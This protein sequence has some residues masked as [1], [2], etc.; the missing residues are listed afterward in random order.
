METSALDLV[1]VG[2]VG[3]V[4]GGLLTFTGGA[5]QAHRAT[6]AR[7]AQQAHERRLASYR[8]RVN[9]YDEILTFCSEIRD[10]IDDVILEDRP[11]NESLATPD[12]LA[13]LDALMQVH[14]SDGLRES[15][16]EWWQA[17]EQTRRT[18]ERWRWLDDPA[19]TS[20]DETASVRAQLEKDRARLQGVMDRVQERARQDVHRAGFESASR[21]APASRPARLVG[22]ALIAAAVLLVTA[23]IW[24][25]LWPVVQQAARVHRDL[26]AFG[27]LVTGFVVVLGGGLVGRRRVRENE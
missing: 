8:E 27:L 15:A 17:F 1:I 20:A 18:L 7:R 4:A 16:R 21:T 3:V 19:N 9:A 5:V 6:V 14:G 12:R 13:R 24:R 10:E 26:V 11:W 25:D 23:P 22:T 2:G